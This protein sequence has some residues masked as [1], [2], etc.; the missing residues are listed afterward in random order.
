MSAQNHSRSLSAAGLCALLTLAACSDDNPM[1]PARNLSPREAAREISVSNPAITLLSVEVAGGE[2][3]QPLLYNLSLADGRSR[4][5]LATPAGEGRQL[6]VRGHDANGNVTHEG[7]ATVGGIRVGQNEPLTVEL[8][9]R[10]EGKPAKLTLDVVGEEP[11]RGGGSIVIEAPKEVLQGQQVSVTATVYDAEGRRLEVDP[12][13]IHWAVS[14]PRLGGVSANERW[15]EVFQAYKLGFVELV[16]VYKNYITKWPIKVL[17]DPYVQVAA[18]FDFTCG[19][20]QSGAVYCWGD[21]QTSQLGTTTAASCF[22]NGYA[23]QCS[24]RPVAVSGGRAF[25]SI[26]SGRAFVCG[27]ETN[28]RISCWGKNDRGQLGVGSVGAPEG[29]PKSLI[30]TSTF[31]ALTTGGEHACAIVNST[32]RPAYCWGLNGNGQLGDGNPGYF[33]FNPLQQPTPV[34]VSGGYGWV[35]IAAGKLHT[36]GVNTETNNRAM[37]WGNGSNG[38]LGTGPFYSEL[39]TPG[40]VNTP[41]TPN[42]NSVY[43]GPDA[44]GTCWNRTGPVSYCN[45]TNDRGQAGVG[46]SSP[47]VGQPASLYGNPALLSIALGTKHVCA[48]DTTDQLWCWGDNT[49][50]QIGFGTTV[51]YFRNHPVP[52][53]TWKFAQVTSGGNHSCGVTRT[54]EVYCWGKNDRGQLGT[55]SFNSTPT[56]SPVQ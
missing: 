11:P 37:C 29:S 9:A 27:I 47:M 2:V 25:K 16:G 28:D 1:A 51:Y 44:T 38:A 33:S 18:G 3:K 15:S 20:R 34:L 26:S 17:F 41:Q 54:G 43:S 30:N 8:F 46:A 6:V 45:G 14:D 56:P 36:C 55:G 40:Y 52:V 50:G 19:R 39:P 13:E 7:N 48:V 31:A 35:S 42:M 4:S 53:G 5:A 12:R 22:A 32:Q 49:D 23:V 24:N 10:G 21:N